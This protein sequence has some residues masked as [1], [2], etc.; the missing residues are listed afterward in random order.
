MK[1]RIFVIVIILIQPFL[2][3][4][5][6]EWQAQTVS[7]TDGKDSTTMMMKGSAQNGNV[8]EE[9]TDVKG[10]GNGAIKKGSYYLFK[11]TSK[12]I[13]IVDP[14]EK[15]YMELPMED[16]MN[17]A[18]Q[19]MNITVSNA[20]ATTTKLA[21]EF[22]NGYPCQ[23][24]KITSSYDMETKVLFMTTKA[25]VE[26][27][28]EIWGTDKIAAKDLAGIYKNRALV[29][30]NKELDK[31]VSDQAAAYKNVSFI[32]KMVSDQKSTDESKNTSVTKS[33]MTISKI[34]QKNIADNLFVVPADYKKTEIG[35]IE[36]PKDQKTDKKDDKEQEIKPEDILKGLFN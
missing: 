34:E 25:H 14:S 24:Y 4:A 21:D 2:M 5:G 20:K 19:V 11:G 30:G 6:I 17:M 23:H 1:I 28:Q 8:R 10:K 32:L 35:K 33:E 36:K 16:M 27:I 12:N 9:I 3:F 13:I 7:S 31:L 15:S 26:Q 22:V 18:G 29:T